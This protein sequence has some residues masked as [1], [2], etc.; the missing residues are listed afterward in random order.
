MLSKAASSVPAR[1]AATGALRTSSHAADGG[2][3]AFN[4]PLSPNYLTRAGGIASFMR[5]PV[6]DDTQ[7]DRRLFFIGVARHPRIHACFVPFA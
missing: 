6:Q 5:L 7:G 4:Q 3:K 1:V 2:A